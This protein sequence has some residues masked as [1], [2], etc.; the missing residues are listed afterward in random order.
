MAGTSAA[1]T[2]VQKKVAGVLPPDV[3]LTVTVT[4]GTRLVFVTVQLNEA[5]VQCWFSSGS[6]P[7]CWCPK[8]KSSGW[9]I[10]ARISS[11]STSRGPG[12]LK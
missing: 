2:T 1:L 4:T 8:S 5:D 3:S 6:Q 7:R 12:R 11:D 10:S 9:R